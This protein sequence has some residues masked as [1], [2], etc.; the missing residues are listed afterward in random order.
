MGNDRPFFKGQKETPGSSNPLPKSSQ[1]LSRFA[2]RSLILNSQFSSPLRRAPNAGEVVPGAHVGCFIGGT[3]L[4]ERNT[5]TALV[6]CTCFFLPWCSLIPSS[7]LSFFHPSFLSSFLSFIPLSPLLSLSL[8][9]CLSRMPFPN[10]AG[11]QQ[12]MS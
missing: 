8:S 9:L 12:R 11:S 2:P 6:S 4:V 1:E 10:L 7:F 5:W 3:D